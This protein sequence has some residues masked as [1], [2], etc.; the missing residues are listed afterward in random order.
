MVSS[1]TACR[2]SSS[3]SV[4][5]CTSATLVPPETDLSMLVT[6]ADQ[7][8]SVRGGVVETESRRQSQAFG[9]AMMNAR[10]SI[11]VTCQGWLR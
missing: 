5:I 2:M 8:H 3:I 4:V 11:L 7:N 1:F 6:W 10:A 9:A